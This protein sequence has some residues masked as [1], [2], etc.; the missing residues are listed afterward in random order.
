[1]PMIAGHPKPSVRYLTFFWAIIKYM[2]FNIVRVKTVNFLNTFCPGHF[3]T[4]LYVSATF[5]S[6]TRC[7]A[8]S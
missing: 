5:F 7:K 1:M 4:T 6:D 8:N 3:L 2:L